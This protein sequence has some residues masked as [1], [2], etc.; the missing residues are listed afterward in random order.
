MPVIQ[1]DH[2]FLSSVS[3]KGEQ[4]RMRTILDA[5][6]GHGTARCYSSVRAVACETR[7][8]DA[9][10]ISAQTEWCDR[11]RKFERSVIQKTIDAIW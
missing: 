6:T 11:V 5:S 2:A 1:F 3:E 9:E 10:Q 7:H 8:L 4:V